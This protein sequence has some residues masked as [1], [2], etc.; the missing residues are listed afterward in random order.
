MTSGDSS[1]QGKRLRQPVSLSGSCLC[2]IYRIPLTRGG[3]EHR[4]PLTRGVACVHGV[5][6]GSVESTK[7]RASVMGR[8]PGLVSVDGLGMSGA[9]LNYKLEI[10]IPRLARQAQWP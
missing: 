7:G 9:S 5:V 4:E 3:R 2:H 10:T 1:G 6:E 8:R